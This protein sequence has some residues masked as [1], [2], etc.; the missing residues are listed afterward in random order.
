MTVAHS[1]RKASTT[2]QGRPKVKETD[3]PVMH[4]QGRGGRETK[5][6]SHNGRS[7]RQ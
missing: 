4:K 3:A 6:A 1:S 5:V 2:H 7:E